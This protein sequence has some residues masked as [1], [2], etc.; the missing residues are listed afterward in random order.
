MGAIVGTPRSFIK[1]IFWVLSNF[2]LFCHSQNQTSLP[3]RKE[4]TI[5][6]NTH[7]SFYALL[8]YLKMTV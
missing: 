1:V 5:I 2:G 8:I 7:N 3:P 4:Q 6:I